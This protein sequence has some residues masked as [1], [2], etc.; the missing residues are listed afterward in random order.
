[1]RLKT[2]NAY[3]DIRK[4]IEIETR[5]SPRLV[6]CTVSEESGNDHTDSYVVKYRRDKERDPD[7][8]ARSSAM[9]ICEVL[10]SYCCTLFQIPTPEPALVYAS[11][12]F[13]TSYDYANLNYIVSEGYHFGTIFQQDVIPVIA[14]QDNPE[15]YIAPYMFI[16]VWIMDCWLMNRDRSTYGNLMYTPGAKG[17]YD[18][19]AVD[20]GECFTGTGNLVDGNCFSGLQSCTERVG[21]PTS[22]QLFERLIID[23][24]G[25]DVFEKSCSEIQSVACSAEFRALL[26][27]IPSQWWEEA[28]IDDSRMLECLQYRAS[29]IG[30]ICL[31]S[32]WE[33][34]RDVISSGT[35][36]ILL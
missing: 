27:T 15:V 29:R 17:K 1:M 13:V 14:E 20:H 33:G 26:H 16:K 21:L 12:R 35:Q 22:N 28:R 32:H 30:D 25:K 5:W 10:G 31:R 2:V 34:M 23:D 24:I 11:E 36:L 9:C 18:I 19:L 3:R 6:D 8:Y 7:L 4:V